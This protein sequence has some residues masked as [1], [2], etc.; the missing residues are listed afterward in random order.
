LIN[1]CYITNISKDDKTFQFAQVEYMGKVV[2]VEVIQPY[3]LSSNPPADS[4][5]ILFDIQ[6]DDNQVAI[7]NKHNERFKN[8]KEWEVQLGNFNTGASIKFEED[9]NI[10]V[11]ATGGK[12]GITNDSGEDLLDLV[13]QILT[14][15]QTLTVTTVAIGSP[16]TVPINTAIFATIQTD[17][18]KLKT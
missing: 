11:N 7:F 12:I 9:G 14:A 3:G 15:I 4:I 6:S 16:T 10:S 1:R 8:L 18:A 13:D 17:L 2:D 5:G